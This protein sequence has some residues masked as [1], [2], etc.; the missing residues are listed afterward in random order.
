MTLAQIEEDD[1]KYQRRLEE[2]IQVCLKLLIFPAQL[3][4]L[5]LQALVYRFELWLPCVVVVVAYT[6]E[7]SD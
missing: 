6:C 3:L 2:A 5:L 1:D 7:E 4:L